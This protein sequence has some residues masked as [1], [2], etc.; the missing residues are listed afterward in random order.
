MVEQ[1]KGSKNIDSTVESKE[2]ERGPLCCN[3]ANVRS[4]SL[5]V[6]EFKTEETLLNSS[7]IINRKTIDIFTGFA[8]TLKKIHIR[9]IMEGYTIKSGIIYKPGEYKYNET[10]STHN[11]KDQ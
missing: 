6:D 7:N 8:V 11:S 3:K 4:P 2:G 5:G 9:L 1:H 10:D